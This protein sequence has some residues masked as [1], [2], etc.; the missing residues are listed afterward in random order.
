MFLL[1]FIENNVLIRKGICENLNL[2]CYTLLQPFATIHGK[3]FDKPTVG[4]IETR[5]LNINENIKLKEKFNL[6]KSTQNIIDI[7]NSIDGSNEL[8]YVDGVHYSPHA[9]KIIAEYIYYIILN[10]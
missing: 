1:E 3:Y 7:S 6:L 8:S 2:N 5:V 9:N 10:F 4:A